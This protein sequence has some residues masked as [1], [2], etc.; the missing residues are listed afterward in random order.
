MGISTLALR[1]EAYANDLIHVWGAEVWRRNRVSK[2]ADCYLT[3]L[4]AYISKF[5]E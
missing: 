4:G 3:L 5:H 2:C 1:S